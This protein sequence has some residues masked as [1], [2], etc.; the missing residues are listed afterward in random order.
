MPQTS[1]K[2]VTI[3]NRTFICCLL[4][5]VFLYLGQNIVNPLVTTY[6]AYTGAGASIIGMISGLY[7]GVS[8]AMRPV[9]GPM[10]T[11]MDK[12]KLMI[13]AF[14][15]G[16]V[17][18][19]GYAASRSVGLFIASR[20]LHG[21]QFSL[22]G[23]LGLTVASDS[24]PKEKMGSGIGIFGLSGIVGTAF[25]PSLGLA[26]RDLGEQTLGEGGGF[27][28]TFLAAAFISAVSV[29]PCILIAPQPKPDRSASAAGP[30][31]HNILSL[32]AVRP[33]VVTALISMSSILANSFMVPYAAE[34]GLSGIGLY[35]TVNAIASLV[36]RPFTGKLLDKKGPA[37]V[38]YPCAVLMAAG[39]LIIGLVH[40]LPAILFAAVLT[41]VGWGTVSPLLQSMAIQVVPPSRRGVASNT[42]FLGFDLGL[43]VGPT[44][45]GLIV[46]QTGSHGA[47]FTASAIPVFL[48]ILVFAFTWKHYK[49]RVKALQTTEAP[50]DAQQDNQ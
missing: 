17:V 46:A 21:V 33:S 9:S 12:K 22:V 44:L 35:F 47:M 1:E 25:G 3:W 42:S 45:A 18:N 34:Y 43:F 50:C 36:S 39:L 29:I 37:F 6:A 28:L 4:A 2:R 24:L 11:M 14:A 32:D 7:F 41:G 23:S 30:W 10:V 5:N 27:F 49:T 40:T 13:F 48:G 20:V 38:F 16:V 31:Y 19:L 15:L 8:F 26:L